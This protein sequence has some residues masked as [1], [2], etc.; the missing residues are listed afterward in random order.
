MIHLLWASL[1]IPILIHMV[2]RRKAKRVQFST[3]RFLRMVDRRVA[4]RQRLK[5]LLLLALRL[6]LL[7]AL[8]GALYRP[9]IR[10]ATFTG[11]NVPAAVAL[12]L[13]DTY[14]MRT[15][16]HGTRRFDRACSVAAEV[17]AGLRKGDAVSLVLTSAAG[18]SPPEPTTDLG[19]LKDLLGTLECGYGTADI[20]PALRRALLSIQGNTNP[21]KEVYV[22][23][24]FQRLCWTDAVA[25][26][27]ASL[28]PDTP[29][30]LID[31]GS[32]VEDNLAVESAEFGLNVQV[33]GAASGLFCTLR[34]PGRR[35]A[36][37][38]LS[39]WLQGAKVDAD[40]ITLA[41]GAEMSAAFEPLFAETGQSWGEVRLAADEVD[42]DNARYFTV[43]V[44]D[45]LPVLLVNGDPSAVAYLDETFFLEMALRAPAT[46]GKTVS[47]IQTQVISADELSEQRLDDYVCVILANV[48]R[49]DDLTAGQLR[50]YVL[51]GGGL[52]LYMGDRVDAASYNAALGTD[53]DGLLPGLLGELR[54]ADGDQD[55]AFK[56]RS[57][58]GEHPLFRG[59]L[60]QMDLSTARVERCL[61]A[62]LQAG[63]SV[64]V[65][66]ELDGGP[67]IL[68]RRCGPG[69]VALCTT[70]ADLDWNNLAAKPF[71][72]PL[73]HQM[74]YHVAR[75][76]RRA[77][78]VPLG[79][80]Y[81]LDLPQSREPLEV[82][83][84][85]VSG[86]GANAND[87]PL[88]TILAEPVGG[89]QRA[90]FTDTYRPGVYSAAYTLGNTE[91]M[92]LFAVNTEP[93]ESSSDRIEPEEA[94]ELFGEAT[95][96]VVTEPD[97]VGTLARRERTGVPLWDQL[98]ALAL[99]VAV[100]ES[101]V[102]NVLLKH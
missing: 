17:V 46:S 25:D 90:T 47:P 50:R 24:D 71:F 51:A 3:L 68:E 59:L 99:I 63:V 84:R 26:V 38:E 44:H 5:E 73:V 9:M 56:I 72:L 61:S 70:S 74:V 2:H 6:I 80:P 31:V 41:S 65:P 49:I 15:T 28:S 93:R 77:E 95:V 91:H 88:A 98:F 34:N 43:D 18:D 21:R 58:D 36:S 85:A 32:D 101:Y 30:F 87:D 81:A 40:E 64:A 8:I 22:I 75:S 16:R 12:V 29:V 102:G 4:R 62:A 42:A 92:H 23:T 82:E 39:L 27:A 89:G 83:F 35:T 78:S 13:D 37:R 97:Q 14:S 19:G 7:A 60:D 96:K 55:D 69:T 20:V 66:V 11:G 33:A 45:K 1:L 57:V 94:A 67:L 53:K 79:M 54:S 76:A 86:P 48:P 100:M 52:I 10:S